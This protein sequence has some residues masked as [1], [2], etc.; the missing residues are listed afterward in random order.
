MTTARWLLAVS[1]EEIWL[2]DLRKSSI[3]ILASV[4]PFIAKLQ[5]V[6]HRRIPD[7]GTYR[8]HMLSFLANTT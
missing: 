3:L 1:A 4:L 2:S 7:L 8:T 5:R 6:E